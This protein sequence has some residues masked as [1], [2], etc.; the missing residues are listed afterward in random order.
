MNNT[1]SPLLIGGSEINNDFLNGYVGNLKIF[2]KRLTPE[3]I[4][5]LYL[6]DKRE[7]FMIKLFS[8]YIDINDAISWSLIFIMILTISLRRMIFRKE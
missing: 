6:K 4:H 8:I 2:N 3:Q 1:N 7:N 5:G